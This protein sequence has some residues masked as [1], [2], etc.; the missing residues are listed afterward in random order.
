M[1]GV[2]VSACIAKVCGYGVERVLTYDILLDSS[3]LFLLYVSQCFWSDVDI[4]QLPPSIFGD[5]FWV[6][7][8]HTHTY[9]H[10]QTHTYMWPWYFWVNLTYMWQWHVWVNLTCTLWR[11]RCFSTTYMLSSICICT[12]IL[13]AVDCSGTVVDCIVSGVTVLWQSDCIL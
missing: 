1:H 12:Y 7:L 5:N 8:T 11:E 6:N 10:T 9:T 13:S 2:Y 3:K 4:Y